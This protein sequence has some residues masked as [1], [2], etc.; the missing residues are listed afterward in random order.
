MTMQRNIILKASLHLVLL[1]SAML[2]GVLVMKF[3]LPP[4]SL[5]KS[6]YNTLQS[7]QYTEMPKQ[8]TEMPKEYTE[9]PKEYTE[10]DVAALISIEQPQDIS[11]RRSELITFLWGSSALPLLSPTTVEKHFKDRRYDDVSSLRNIDK[12]VITMEYGLKSYAYHF[13]PRQPNNRLVLYHQGHGGDFILSKKQI[14]QFL[15]NGYA[16]L[17]FA[18][19]LLG[20]NNQPIVEVPRIGRLKMTS[21]DHMKFLS[22]ESGHPVKYFI[23]PVIIAL[24][25]INE[26]FDYLSISMVG[27]SGGGWTATLVAAVDTR[28]GYSFPVAGSYPIYL[29][30]HSQRDWGDYEQT[31]PELYKKV[32]YLE[33]YVLGSHGENRKQIQIIN[34]FDACCFAGVKWQ[35]YK[36]VVKERVHQLGSGKYDLF[37]DSSHTKHLIS[38]IAMSRILDEL[39]GE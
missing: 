38:D 4:Y 24:N 26:S 15:D 25:Y 1:M 19:P 6:G 28:I 31:V 8:Y 17:A 12:L 3:Q 10:T 32:N 37:M 20:L 33:L 5:L 11:Q 29:R 16:V 35:T 34:Q 23:E 39:E 9:I 27:I 2:Y 21:H 13:I 36:D 22:P 7:K 14:G 18:M 30:S